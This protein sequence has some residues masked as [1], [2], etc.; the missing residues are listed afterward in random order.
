MTQGTI[1]TAVIL[2]AGIGKR[3]KS[4]FDNKPKGFLTFGEKPIIEDSLLNLYK[5]GINDIILVTGYKGEYYEELK[6]TYPDLKTVENSRYASSG[7][8]YSLYCAKESIR[9]DFLLLESDIVYEPRAITELITCSQKD[10]ILTAGLSNSSD[11]VFVETAENN[12][13]TMSKK[14]SDLHAVNEELVG[15]TKISYLLFLKMV[16]YVESIIPADY[17]IN[18]E[19]D[20]LV[21]LA[22]EHPVYCHKVEDLLWSEIDTD[23]HYMRVKNIIY[24]QI[25]NTQKGYTLYGNKA[26]YPS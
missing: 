19:T 17:H 22:K 3:I 7:S 10:V 21:T 6:Q 26:E 5:Q 9:E 16:Q 13:V 15:I 24:P 20:C 25:L 12:L 8:M 23:D 2:A 1:T 14:R 11:E 18:Y 4:I